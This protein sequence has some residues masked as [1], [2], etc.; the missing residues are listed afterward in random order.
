LIYFNDIGIGQQIL[1]CPGTAAFEFLYSGTR[2]AGATR[3]EC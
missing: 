3:Q 2:K 1:A